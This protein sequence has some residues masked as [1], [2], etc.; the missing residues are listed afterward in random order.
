MSNQ[1]I[2]PDTTPEARQ[3]AMFIYIS[4]FLGLLIPLGN[5]IA[6]LVLWLMKKESHPFIDDQGKEV[7]NFQLSVL[8]VFAGLL[9]LNMLLIL[10][11]I[12]SPLVFLTGLLMFAL[13]VYVVI[14][15]IM[16][17]VKAKEGVHF[18]FPYTVRLI[19]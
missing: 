4:S 18:R 14:I 6:P 9:I 7:I 16:G 1:T 2:F 19:K 17:A 5:L 12:L 15:T 11:V 3:F 8:I 10:T 13:F